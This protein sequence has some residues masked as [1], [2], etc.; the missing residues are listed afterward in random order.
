MKVKYSFSLILTIISLVGMLAGTITVTV[1]FIERMRS[2]TTR[3]MEAYVREQTAHLRNKLNLTFESHEKALYQTTAAIAAMYAKSGAR[4]FNANAIPVEDMR[5]FLQ[6]NLSTMK[7]VTQNY[8]VNNIAASEPGGYG[9]FY[10]RWDFPNNY[11]QRVRPFFK[12]AKAKG[13]AISFTDPYVALATQ[14]FST[15]IT[16][17]IYD[18]NKNDLGV[19][20]LDIAVSSLTDITNSQKSIDGMESWLLN[21]EGIFIS[22]RDPDKVMKINFFEDQNL[23]KY[24]QG[25]LG[26]ETFYAM[27]SERI[28]CSALIPGPNWIVIT[29]LPTKVVFAELNN[30]IVSTIIFVIGL[31]VVLFVILIFVIRR[32][33]KPIGTIANVLKDISEGEGDLTRRITVNVNNEIGDL[34]HYFNETME[35]IR[36]LIEI[37]KHKIDALTNTGHELSFNMAKT[38]KSIDQISSNFE[39]MK[40][41]MSQQEESAAEADKAVKDIKAHIGNLNKM[42]EEQSGSISASSSAVEEMIANIHS[43]TNT[44]IENSKNV[45][46]LI[47]ASE[48]GKTGVQT[49]AQ[50]IQ[51]IAKDSEGLLQINSVM[52]NIAAQTNLLSMNAAIEAAHAGES[53]KGFAVVAGE[54]RK[55]AESSSNQSKTTA[56]ML[57][58]IKSSIDSITASSNEVLSRFGIIDNGVKTV[59]THEENIRNA[60]EEQESGGKQ[61]LESMSRLKEISV[62]VKKGAVEMQELGNYLDDETDDFIAISNE[63]MN[64]MNDIVNGAMKEIKSAVTLVDEMS[65]ENSRNFDDLKTESSKFKVETG[66]EKKKVLVVDD[67][68]TVLTLTRS[69]LEK[70]YDVTTANSGKEALELLFQGLVPHLVLLDLNM[71]EMGG[72]DTFIR[73]RDLSRLHKTPIAIYTTSEDPKDK[74]KARELGAVDY[75]KKPA[76]KAELIKKVANLIKQ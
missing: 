74:A 44:L 52:D 67:E 54:I 68:Q 42:I 70:D 75:I 22:N 12:D 31:V 24:K 13:G 4:E 17:I 2:M 34:A 64:G 37:M 47:K 30:T 48:N 8:I 73:I 39:G 76:A 25:V 18:N 41:K 46:N 57:K 43:V 38:S 69:S 60:M 6:R 36:S 72:W 19:V 5:V 56:T 59:S 62:T 23:G 58:K 14:T 26:N 16:T 32:I 28:I 66:N 11:D 29:T 10:P 71:P 45:D 7:N 50:K 55:L 61:I 21:K 63:S 65:A 9:V 20:G 3:Q 1:I 15:S 35:K 49:V 27:D 40:G 53:G 33:T 51:E